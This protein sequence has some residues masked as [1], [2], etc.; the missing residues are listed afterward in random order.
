MGYRVA[1]VGATGNVGRG[2]LKELAHSEIEVEKVFALASEKSSGKEISYGDTNTT[3]SALQDFN[4]DNVDIVFFATRAKISKEYVIPASQKVKLVV[5]LSSYFRMHK[6]IPLVVP[7]VNL[8]SLALAKK[9][10]II[11]NPN[12]VVI[13]MVTALKKLDDFAKVSRLVVSTYQSVS[14]AGKEAMDNLYSQTK[15]KMFNV[16]AGN[17]KKET[18]AF[19]IIPKIDEFAE[20]GYTQEEIKVINETKK[21]LSE[22]IEVTAT[23]VRIPV[24]VGHSISVN[25]EFSK[26][27]SAQTAYDIL[28]NAEGVITDKRHHTPYF[29]PLDCVGQDEVFVSRIRQDTAKNILNL[30]IVSDNLKKG[31]GLNAIQIAEKYIKLYL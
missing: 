26:N 18:I 17:N 20:N 13:P 21:I 6:D 31:A 16:F 3:V 12:C 23:C 10:K 28:E 4:F 25:A 14:G 2:V 1:V 22:D 11:T 9:S 8:E 5:D 30:W 27:I 7:E 19:N 24:F 15:G 29:T